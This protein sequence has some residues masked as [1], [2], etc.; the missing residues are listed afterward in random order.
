MRWME[1]YAD[2]CL[3]VCSDDDVGTDSVQPKRLPRWCSVFGKNVLS[4][5]PFF[6]FTHKH[7]HMGTR[8]RIRVLHVVACVGVIDVCCF[9]VN[10]M[11]MFMECSHIECRQCE[12]F[13]ECVHPTLTID[14]VAEAIAFATK[15]FRRW[16]YEPSS[17]HILILVYQSLFRSGSLVLQPRCGCSRINVAAL[18]NARVF[19]MC[20]RYYLF[21]CSGVRAQIVLRPSTLLCYAIAVAV[22]TTYS[23]YTHIQSL[24]SAHERDRFSSW[25]QNFTKAAK[26]SAEEA[27]STTIH[28]VY[29]VGSESID[30]IVYLVPFWSVCVCVRYFVVVVVNSRLGIER[31]ISLQCTVVA[32]YSWCIIE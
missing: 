27:P 12:C 2:T 16:D 20:R 15:T 17:A 8:M 5:D 18:A 14:V 10:D 6:W 22:H 3:Y 29:V 32:R 31:A 13:S 1:A 28:L 11:M 26:A 24:Q 23:Y 9:P 19:C 21:V 30:G 4:A 25:A 7:K